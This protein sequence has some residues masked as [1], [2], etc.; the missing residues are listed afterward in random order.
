MRY[1]P[2]R[3]CG[4]VFA[5]SLAALL[6][7]VLAPAGARA[8]QFILVDETIT[9]TKAEADRTQSH[10]F[11]RNISMKPGVPAN[12]TAPVNYR[13]GVVH[14][15]VDVI[16]KPSA[17]VNQWSLCYIPNRGQGNGYGC[18]GTGRYTTTGA[19]DHEE[20]MT[21]WWENQSIV[22]T[23]GVKE[24]HLVVKDMNDGNGHLHR[25]PD[26]ANF[27]P[28]KVRI[29]MVQ[30]SAGATYDPS[31][32]PNA[33]SPADGGVPDAGPV[34]S[35]AGS[36]G[37]GGASGAGGAGGMGGGSGSGGA[38]AWAGGS[39][40]SGASGSGGASAGAGGATSAGGAGGHGG[41]APTAAGGGGGTS[42]PAGGAAQPPPAASSGSVAGGCA[43]AGVRG[44]PRGHDGPMGLALVALGLTLLAVRRRRR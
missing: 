19:F 4:N 21:S 15:R 40:G 37:N 43:L 1:H 36:G 25:R 41:S 7:A 13:N 3:L 5:S 30:V 26:P 38:G 12:W 10:Y 34:A 2:A 28:F 22:W 31:I 42:P 23:Q 11:V 8:E 44:G 6:T 14:V 20:S 9:M 35:D 39:S 32:I 17:E 29:T 33:G 18:A 24:M 27:F 16:E